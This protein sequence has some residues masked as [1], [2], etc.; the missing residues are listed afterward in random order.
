MKPR[1]RNLA[2]S[3]E[4]PLLPQ[5]P[6]SQSKEGKIG[7]DDRIE[8]YLGREPWFSRLPNA[9]DITVRQLMNHTSGLV[10]YEFKD[11]FTKDLTAN[12]E[13]IWKPA[14]LVA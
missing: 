5:P 10:R 11:Q 12:P 14:E 13:K 6:G 1:D 8:K 3:V 9:T 2:G 4:R 7:L